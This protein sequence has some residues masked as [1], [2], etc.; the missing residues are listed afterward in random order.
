MCVYIPSHTPSSDTMAAPSTPTALIAF[1][2]TFIL[3]IHL[4]S[5][6]WDFF[7]V[8]LFIYFAPCTF[9]SNKKG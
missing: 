8:L 9:L 1:K 5:G 7:Y 4:F 2:H 3:I 6:I